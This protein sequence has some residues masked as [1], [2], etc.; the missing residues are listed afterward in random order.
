MRVLALALVAAAVL[1]ACGKA[2]E[3]PDGPAGVADLTVTVDPDGPH[4]SAA[5]RKL[6]LSCTKPDQSDACG[7]AAGVSQADLRPTPAKV[8]CSQ[9]YSGPQTASIVG[10]LRG[11]RVDAHFARNNGCETKRWNGVADLL[12]QVR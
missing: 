2:A 4:G 11:Q 3:R 9:L 1:A 8:A 5:P 12:Q 6:H 7:A 10:I